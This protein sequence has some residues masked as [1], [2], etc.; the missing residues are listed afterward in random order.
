[1][2]LAAALVAAAA[3]LCVAAA[4]VDDLRRYAI[5]DVWPIAI[6]VLYA[7]HALLVPPASWLSHGAAPAVV[8]LAGL[9]GFARGYVG[10]GDV[11]LLTAIA[12][13]TGLGGLPD[14]L[15]G[16][17][18]AGGILALLLIAARSSPLA[19]HGVRL[20][21]KTA[22]VPYA[23]AIAAGTLAWAWRSNFVA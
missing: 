23:V 12:A 22:P 13:W 19:S 16:T 6:A 2:L 8:F 11:K 20:F 9:I 4:A 7:I 5:A 18:V 17:A 1:M 21:Q 14:L 15:G 3:L 10:G